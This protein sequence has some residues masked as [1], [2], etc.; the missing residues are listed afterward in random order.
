MILVETIGREPRPCIDYRKLNAITKTQYFPLPN[1]E[2][3]V[4]RVAA[5]NYI[6]V[7]DLTKGYW[8][9]LLTK[10]TQRYAG[11]A[12]NFGCY[13]PKTMPFGLVSAPFTFS[14]FMAEL[15]KLCEDFCVPYLD[16]V[17]FFFKFTRRTC[18]APRCDVRE[19]R[20]RQTK[21]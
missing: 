2:E 9:L 8:Q 3:R 14:K 16:E 18:K 10:R 11:F 7:L 17:A 5:A 21:N 15:L 12:T 1:I 13:F 19:N 4:E 6:S 20:K